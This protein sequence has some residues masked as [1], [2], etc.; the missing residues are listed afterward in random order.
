MLIFIGILVIGAAWLHLSSVK[1]AIQLRNYPHA[2]LLYEDIGDAGFANI[3]QKNRYYWVSNDISDVQ[4]Y[5]E[6]RFVIFLTSHD[7]YGEW[8]ISRFISNDSM[9]TV[10]DSTPYLLHHT[11]CPP[12]E[13]SRCV[14]V[15]LIDVEQED[16]WRLAI[17]SPGFRYLEP[18]FDIPSSGTLIIFSY[19]Q[20]DY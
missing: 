15:S 3:L 4:D 11:L 14:T 10:V 20:F 6:E 16:V 18:P 5:F 19:M 17:M 8:L 2:Q 13:F 12:D 9:L 1:F 7:D